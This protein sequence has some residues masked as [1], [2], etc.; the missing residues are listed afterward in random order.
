MNVLF[1]C[2]YRG[3]KKGKSG[4]FQAPFVLEEVGGALRQPSMTRN[5]K[6]APIN[7]DNHYN[8]IPALLGVWLGIST[9][10]SRDTNIFAFQSAILFVHSPMVAT[11]KREKAKD[12]KII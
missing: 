3:E 5:S 8:H 7:R 1:L 9:F 12:S 10:N 4:H 11:W 2:C 6:N